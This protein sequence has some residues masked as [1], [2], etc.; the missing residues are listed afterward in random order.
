MYGPSC[1]ARAA[2]LRHRG[3]DDLEPPPPRADNRPAAHRQREHRRGVPEI[4]VRDDR[5]VVPFGALHDDP[6]ELLA[7]LRGVAVRRAE[8]E[9]PYAPERAHVLVVR[10]DAV[11]PL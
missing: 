5:K 1:E 10:K 11:Y 9:A 6:V 2:H 8:E 3:L 4:H 7:L